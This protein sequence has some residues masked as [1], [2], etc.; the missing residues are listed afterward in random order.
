MTTLSGAQRRPQ[1]R[2]E[3]F[4]VL[5]RLALRGFGG[6]LAQAQRVLVEEEHWLSSAEFTELFAVAQ[7][8][9]GPNVVNLALMLGRRYFGLGGAV[10]AALAM[11]G[12]P[13]IVVLLIAGLWSELADWPGLASAL[14]SALRGMV[15]ASIGL[16]SATGLK[17]L[18]SA[19]PTPRRL[20]VIGTAFILTALLR[21]PLAWVIFGLAPVSIVMAARAARR[22]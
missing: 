14:G 10:V 9:P 18:R 2:L 3:L 12:V 8:I 21:V 11:L 17:M 1:S 19:P 20:V 15:A 7:V 13:A 5:T 22:P 6:V 16:I 4:T